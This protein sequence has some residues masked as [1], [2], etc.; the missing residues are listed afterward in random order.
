MPPDGV[1]GAGRVRARV[2]KEVDERDEDAGWARKEGDSRGRRG[3][4]RQEQGSFIYEDGREKASQRQFDGGASCSVAR[5]IATKVAKAQ[6]RG[7]QGGEGESVVE[8]SGGCCW[9]FEA[10]RL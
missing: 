3:R 9:L 5:A 4:K 8:A 6:A 10:T 7:S 2:A 1:R